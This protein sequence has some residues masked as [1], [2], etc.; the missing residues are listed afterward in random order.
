MF[1]GRAE[2]NA[3]PNILYEDEVIHHFASCGYPSG[4]AVLMTTDRRVLLVDKVPFSL[5]VEDVPY[6]CITSIDYGLG[7]ITG[8]ISINTFSKKLH[9]RRI[10]RMRIPHIATHI[11]F[12]I[13]ELNEKGLMRTHMPE[14]E[15]IGAPAMGRGSVFDGVA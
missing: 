11:Q 7:L 6:D 2:I 8:W 1:L 10:N 12:K 15:P 5:I 4:I 3:L 13:R 14:S 9:M